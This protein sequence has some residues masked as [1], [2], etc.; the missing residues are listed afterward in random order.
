MLML[1]ILNQTTNNMSISNSV[2]MREMQIKS[3]MRNHFISSRMAI[4]KNSEEFLSWLM[5]PTSTHEDED[6]TLGLAQWVKDPA[7]L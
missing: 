2:V 3:T 6:S 4:T 1:S 7:L 5:N